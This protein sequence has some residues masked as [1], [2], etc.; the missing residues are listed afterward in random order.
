MIPDLYLNAG[1][2]TV[3]YFEWLKNKAGVSFDR[4]MSRH[5]ELVKRELLEEMESLAGVKIEPE[6]KQQLIRG[7][8]E[9]RLVNATLEQT[10]IRSYQ[11]I[12]DCWKQRGLPDLRTA[13]FLFAI[14]RV[15][16]SYQHHGIFP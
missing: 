9:E 2:V 8:Q 6:K 15:A 16:E 1:G 5:E 10:M 14:E 12:H 7:P 4:M 13:S 11:K 3:S